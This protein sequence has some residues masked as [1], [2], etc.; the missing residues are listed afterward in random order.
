MEITSWNHQHQLHSHPS[1]VEHGPQT[2]SGQRYEVS[3]EKLRSEH[4]RSD[5]GDR[6]RCILL[7]VICLLLFHPILRH[8]LIGEVRQGW[9]LTPTEK[10]P[11]NDLSSYY[12]RF[13]HSPLPAAFSAPSC[14]SHE[15]VTPKIHW[16]NRSVL[17]QR[18]PAE[19]V[20]LNEWAGTEDAV[21]INS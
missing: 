2:A 13:N 18:F 8:H 15:A 10:P 16:G 20:T 17:F 5:A 4:V 19:P 14:P 11:Q 1:G 6:R 7:Q 3:R 12:R 9:V 21:Q